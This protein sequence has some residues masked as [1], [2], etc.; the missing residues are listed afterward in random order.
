MYPGS[1]ALESGFITVRPTGTRKYRAASK[2][3]ATLGFFIAAVKELTN[4]TIV[5]ILISSRLIYLVISY[6]LLD[7]TTF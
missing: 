4:I 7:N 6:I 1:Y 2:T 3:V 5:C